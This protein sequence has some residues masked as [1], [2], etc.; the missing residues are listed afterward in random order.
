[1]TLLA[2]LA[3]RGGSLFPASL[4]LG[5]LVPPVAALIRPHLFAVVLALTYLALVRTDLAAA[6]AELRRPTALAGIVAATLLVSPPLAWAACRLLG[7]DA[8]LTAA[9]VV[10]SCAPPITSAPA[11]ARIMG[12]DASFALAGSVAGMLAT[13]FTAPPLALGL[14]GLD[15]ALSVSGMAARLSLFVGMPMLAA[16]ATRRL[17]G[18]FV[19]RQAAAFDGATVLALAIFATGVM[20]GVTALAIAQPGRAAAMALA[21][22]AHNALFFVAGAALFA[23]QPRPRALT[24]GLLVGNRQMALML[25]VLPPEAPRDVT[26]YLAIAQ[27]PLYLNP[28]LLRPLLR[29]LLPPVRL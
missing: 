5:L 21:A 29:R 20:D 27:L 15:L 18:G 16:I 13:P 12:L 9:L 2:T 17:A 14:A 22:F 10:V 8:G 25:A 3:G 28:F 24:A 11:F 6:G 4:A 26:L 23:A 1:M 19:A 7:L